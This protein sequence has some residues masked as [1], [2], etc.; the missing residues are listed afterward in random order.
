MENIS[1]EEL[2]KH[3]STNVLEKNSNLRC[4]GLSKVPEAITDLTELEELDLSDNY[5]EELP[6]SINKLKNLLIG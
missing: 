1:A 6:T 2:R 4:R 3:I 5:L